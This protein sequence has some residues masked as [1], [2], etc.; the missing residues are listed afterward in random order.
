MFPRFFKKSN[1]SPPPFISPPSSPSRSS[2]LAC[3]FPLPSTSHYS[4]FSS[5]RNSIPI[6]D[7][8]I[9]KIIRLIGGFSFS[10]PNTSAN[11]LLSHFSNS[12]PVG[13]SS[14][15]LESFISSFLDSLLTFGNAIGEIVLSHDNSNIA[16]LFNSDLN[17]VHIT[18]STS[19]FSLNFSVIN[20]DLSLSPIQNPQLVLFSALNPPPSNIFGT[21][22][23]HNLPFVSS[24]LLKIYDSIGKNFERMGNLRFAVSYKP[25]PLPEDAPFNNQRFQQVASAWSSAM[26]DSYDGK[27]HDFIT[28]GD[29]DIKVIGADNQLIDSNV[30]VRQILEQIISKLSIPPFL[31]GINWSTSERMSK[32]QADILTSELQYYRRLLSPILIRVASLFLH[33][34]G[35]NLTPSISWANIN[36]QDEIEFAQARLYNA[37]ALS[38]E[39]SLS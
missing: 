6:I 21:S 13:P 32:Q 3:S 17:C 15:G 9:L 30:P 33:L 11:T 19:P 26:S 14:F 2:H 25:S 37:Q 24:I 12:V 20:S 1:P 36:L 29:V 16:G 22:I 18:P 10:T 7:A 39:Q 35:F 28:S 8:A 5:I 31:L 27:V 23:L 38:L 34:N 4:L